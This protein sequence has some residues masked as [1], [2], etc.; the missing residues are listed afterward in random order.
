MQMTK[1]R[2]K[3][4]LILA[5]SLSIFEARAQ[6]SH[7]GGFTSVREFTSPAYPPIARAAHIKGTVIFLVTF[8][9]KGNVESMTSLGGPP[10]LIPPAASVVQN[11]KVN[12]YTSPRT[13]PFVVT[14]NMPRKGRISMNCRDHP[15]YNT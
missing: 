1:R 4:L 7:C 12:P 14:F 3:L 11:M 2:S 13:C 6:V 5:T 8:D 9:L 10:R 15:T